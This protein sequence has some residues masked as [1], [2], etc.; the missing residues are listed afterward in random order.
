MKYIVILKRLTI[1]SLCVMCAG[2]SFYV[3]CN[4]WVSHA[5]STFGNDQSLTK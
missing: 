5:H 2:D 4:T 3:E 1:V